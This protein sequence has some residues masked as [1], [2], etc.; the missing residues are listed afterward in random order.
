M[1]ESPKRKIRVAVY[2]RKSSEERLDRE[3]NSLHSQFEACAAYVASQRAEGWVLIETPYSDGGFSGGSMDRP[4]LQ[5][6]LADIEAGR[7]DAVAT[8]K[9]DRLSRSLSDFNKLTDFFDRHGVAYVSVTQSFNTATAMG[10]LMRNVLA[11]FAEFERAVT[12]ERIRD[13]I[14]AS[15][16]KGK[17]CGGNVP[18]GYALVNRKLVIDEAEAALVRRIFTR[19]VQLGS[20]TKLVKELQ[21]EGIVTKRGS[22]FDKANVYMLL[23]NRVYIGLAVHKGEAFPGEHQA[24]ID[25]RLWAQVQAL[26]KTSPRAR[27]NANRTETAALLKG[28]I[29][30]PAG[31]ALSP[32]HT[33]KGAKRYAYYALNA[34]LK[35]AVTGEAAL[36]VPAAEIDRAVVSQVRRLLIAPEII[37]ETWNAAR[38]SLPDLPEAQVREALVSFD[39]LWDQLFAQEQRRLIQLLVER[40][41]VEPDGIAI[42]LR[43]GGLSGLV[44]DLTREEAA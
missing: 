30:D 31:R 21:A 28:L 29:F 12:T 22:P 3:F 32:T 1:T 11:S 36:R 4:G 43:T 37:V 16:R 20:A 19:F 26:L 15:R 24:I 25:E 33:K 2:V 44:L 7:V 38:A 17:W 5:R 10:K 41:E 39:Q 35:S 42:R 18:L 23:R 8:Y 27:A 6:L 13:K 34:A 40:V 9:I 14:A